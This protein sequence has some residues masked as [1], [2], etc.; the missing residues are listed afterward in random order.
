MIANMTWDKNI[1]HN[2]MLPL[3]EEV[4]WGFLSSSSKRI[5]LLM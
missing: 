3:G 2:C 5:V 1:K 4:A